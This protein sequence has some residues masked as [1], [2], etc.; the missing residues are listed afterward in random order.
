M[1]ECPCFGSRNTTTDHEIYEPKRDDSE[2][3]SDSDNHSM[4]TRIMNDLSIMH[5]I[6]KDGLV[7]AYY[8]VD[9]VLP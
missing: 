1:A 7:Q 8:R 9:I 5:E 6:H 4:I 3:C 2:N